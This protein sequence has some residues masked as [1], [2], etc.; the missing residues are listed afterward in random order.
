MRLLDGFDLALD[1][2][3]ERV[4][5]VDDDRWDTETPCAAWSVRDLVN[6][7]TSEHL[8]APWL[9]R[10]A[11]L[12]EV[13]DRFD[14]DVLGDDPVAAWDGAAAGSRAAFHASGALDTPVQTSGG[15]T[16]AEEYLSQMA[17]DLAVH[18]WDLAR[19]IEVDDR[20]DPGVADLLLGY[21][22]E[23]SAA[24]QNLGIFDPPVPV[25]DS[26]PPQDRLIAVLG[27]RP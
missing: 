20:I 19:G 2:F 11:T 1:T 14:G 25:P 15:P 5:R 21:A 3:S 18:G 27:R 4:H 17:L 12:A 23:K 13:G 8:W 16:P 9:L 26:A 6:H 24:W 7:L 22:E 10:G